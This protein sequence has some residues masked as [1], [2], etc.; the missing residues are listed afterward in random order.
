MWDVSELWKFSL[1]TTRAATLPDQPQN[2]VQWH[3]RRQSFGGLWPDVLTAGQGGLVLGGEG[4]V[5][6]TF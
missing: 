3:M 4:E 6:Q 2:P 1:E 5:K